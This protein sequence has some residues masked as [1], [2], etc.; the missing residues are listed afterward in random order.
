MKEHKRYKVFV[1]GPIGPQFIADSIAKHSTKTTIGAHDIF[2]GQV[3]SDVIENKTV[4]AIEYTTYE[5]MAEEKFHIIREA[6]FEQF[7]LTCMHI[8]HS[9]GKIK[10][11]EICLFVFVSSKHR[12]QAFD[13]CRYIVEEIK[14][15]VPIWGKEIFEDETF[16]WKENT[17]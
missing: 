3:R 6:A 14:A 12:L 11:G 10:A 5:E 9:L 4:Q 13:A 1:N 17:K 8:Y 7:D 15:H 16:V 2:L